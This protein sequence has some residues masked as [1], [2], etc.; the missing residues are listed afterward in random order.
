VERY[1]YDWVDA[2]DPRRVVYDATWCG[3]YYR[4]PGRFL[5]YYPWN[6]GTHA[7]SSLPYTSVKFGI[8]LAAYL[9]SVGGFGY[10]CEYGDCV[11]QVV[12]SSTKSL[13]EVEVS[14]GF[15]GVASLS[16]LHY[17][18]KFLSSWYGC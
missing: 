18:A 4:G 9:G 12:F 8:P 7:Y 17:I 16:I 15:K 3:G 13:R 5:E 6:M 10:A 14:V 2:P 11:G 1:T